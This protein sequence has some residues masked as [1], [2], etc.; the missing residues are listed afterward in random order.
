MKI[1]KED[2]SISITDDY[3]LL[4]Y[5]VQSVF[6]IVRFLLTSIYFE[7]ILEKKLNQCVA[8][9]ALSNNLYK[10]GGSMIHGN[11]SHSYY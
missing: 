2:D 4:H 9:V 7:S 1:L 6:Y 5:P 8:V 3:L 10:A 11:N